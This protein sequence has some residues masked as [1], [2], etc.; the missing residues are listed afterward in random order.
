[1]DNSDSEQR[2][3]YTPDWLACDGVVDVYVPDGSAVGDAGRRTTVMGIGAHAD[4]LE[5]GAAWAIMSCRG[6]E[7]AWFSGVTCTDG[8]GSGSGPSG[9]ELAGEQLVQVRRNEQRLAAQLGG[10]SL[11]VQLGHPSSDVAS[12]EAR[13][14]LV[15][16]LADLIAW[17]RPGV[18]VTHNPVDRHAT[19]VGVALAVLEACW[20]LPS[21]LRPGRVLG[22]EIWRSLDWLCDEDRVRQEVV[23]NL[24]VAREL[25]SVHVSQLHGKS[26]DLAGEGRRIANATFD[27]T[28]LAN[29]AEQLCYCVDL[30]D[31]SAGGPDDVVPYVEALVA[32]FAREALEPLGKLLA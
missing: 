28:H 27:S 5:L 29:T 17:S 32:R 7:S 14:G 20:S 18:V 25:A 1:M 16:Q 15:G 31:L 26:Y 21:E 3:H 6:S 12:C 24:E 19:H 10:Y 2:R 22:M 4:D 23:G 13:S 11:Q 30:T 9:P 8:A